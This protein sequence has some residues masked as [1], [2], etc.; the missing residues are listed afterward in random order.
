MG[1]ATDA[2]A[3]YLCIGADSDA[4]G[5]GENFFLGKIKRVSIYSDPL[6]AGNALYLF[7]NR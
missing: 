2:G 7:Q 6:T 4:S 3:Q 1:F 5:K